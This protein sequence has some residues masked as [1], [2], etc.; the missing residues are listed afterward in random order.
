MIEK[1]NLLKKLQKEPE[2][3]CKECALERKTLE[4]VEQSK[5]EKNE[6]SRSIVIEND[7]EIDVGT[8]EVLRSIVDNYKVDAEYL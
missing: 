5:K 7:M 1:K 4:M 8:G 3:F 6:K 2:I